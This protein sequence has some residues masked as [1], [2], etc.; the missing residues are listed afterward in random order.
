MKERYNVFTNRMGKWI[1]EDIVEDKYLLNM[2]QFLG[3]EDK[4]SAKVFCNE[5]NKLHK[6]IMNVQGKDCLNCPKL[7][8]CTDTFEIYVLL[9]DILKDNDIYYIYNK[10]DFEA[11]DY[12]FIM[13]IN[14]DGVKDF[15]KTVKVKIYDFLK[16]NGY[17]L[18]S[19]SVDWNVLTSEWSRTCI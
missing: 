19:E 7:A 17:N 5:L 11:L 2:P 8:K 15:H 4:E 1:I 3:F 16:E 18:L 13:K 10:T 14:F 6:D 9:K 12:K